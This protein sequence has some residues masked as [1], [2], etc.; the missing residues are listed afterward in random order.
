[1]IEVAAGLL[2]LVV[3]DHCRAGVIANLDLLHSHLRVLDRF[4]EDDDD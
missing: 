1:M 4:G 3:P 2:D